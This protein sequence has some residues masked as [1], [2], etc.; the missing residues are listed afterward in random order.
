MFAFNLSV[1]TCWFEN[2]FLF[3]FVCSSGIL[4]FIRRTCRCESV[5][6]LPSPPPQSNEGGGGGKF[7]SCRWRFLQPVFDSC[8][9]ELGVSRP[10]LRRNGVLSDSHVSSRVIMIHLFSPSIL[11]VWDFLRRLSLCESPVVFLFPTFLALLPSLHLHIRQT[12]TAPRSQHNE[13]ESSQI[14]R[15]HFY[16]CQLII[17]ETDSCSPPG[18]RDGS[19]GEMGGFC[20]RGWSGAIFHTEF[21]FFSRLVLSGIFVLLCSLGVFPLSVNAFKAAPAF[22]FKSMWVFQNFFCCWRNCYLLVMLHLVKMQKY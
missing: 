9:A 17:E 18:T 1:C 22:I 3:L 5:W 12:L 14:E 16:S 21:L 13:I 7:K 2:W 15:S 19:D 4:I 11:A 20:R 10:R 8:C 6:W